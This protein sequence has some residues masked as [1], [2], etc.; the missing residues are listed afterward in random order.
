MMLRQLF[1]FTGLLL[2]STLLLA[3]AGSQKASGQDS[4][5]VYLP[6][7]PKEPVQ[8][9][10]NPDCECVKYAVE[11]LFGGPLYPGESWDYAYQM[12]SERYF[13]RQEAGFRFRT[14][15]PVSGFAIIFQPGSQFQIKYTAG[16]MQGQWVDVTLNNSAGHIGIIQSSTYLYPG[17]WEIV[18]RS[19]NWEDTYGW[20]VPVDPEYGCANVGDSTIR[21]AMSEMGISFWGEGPWFINNLN[22][23]KV[24]DVPSW[25]QTDAELWQY[26]HTGEENQLWWIWNYV[27]DD[28]DYEVRNDWSWRCMDVWG[29]SSLPGAQIL[30]YSC[31][32]GGNQQWLFNPVYPFSYNIVSKSS[33]LC[34]DVEGE[35]LENGAYLIQNT[36]NGSDSQKWFLESGMDWGTP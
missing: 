12:A 21:V 34:L 26:D 22:S 6:L 15:F 2:V 32:Y 18:M 8:Y 29:D 17:T 11:Y 3:G 25:A 16:A 13:G 5:N 30:Q 23:L 1:R 10:Q 24:I 35:S 20:T 9:Y 27:D 33:G 14:P 4:T 31:H 28:F 36:C 19:A 7:I